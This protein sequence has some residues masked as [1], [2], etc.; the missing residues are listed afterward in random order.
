M[1]SCAAPS[2]KGDDKFIT[3]DY[4]QQC[5]KPFYEVL[6]EEFKNEKKLITEARKTEFTMFSDNGKLYVINSKGNT[7]RLEP[8][9]VN[10]FFEEYKKTGSM[11]TSSYQDITFNSSY[12]LAALQYLMEK[13]L[14]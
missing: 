5:P 14:I 12:L 10:N 7:R 4:L 6:I 2:A 13:E 8:M 9:Y 11:S 1:G 3:T